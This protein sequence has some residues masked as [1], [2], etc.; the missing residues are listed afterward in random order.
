MDIAGKTGTSNDAR[1]TWFI[2]VSPKLAVGVWVGFDD[3]RRSVGRSE[4][5]STAALPIF[6]ELMGKIGK[7]SQRFSRPPEVIDVRIDEKTGLLA[8]DGIS[9][10][11]YVEV[12]LPGTAPV[13]VA[14]RPGEASVDS[15][16][17]DQYDGFG[18]DGDG[19][20]ESDDGEAP[21]PSP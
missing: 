10:G 5:G 14:P 19:G 6:V 21:E 18:G 8:A 12:F 4:G 16:A 15:F 17:I 2:G 1:D 3:F 11:T 9:E 20:E 13:E 7:K